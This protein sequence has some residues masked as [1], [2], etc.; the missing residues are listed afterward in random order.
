MLDLG[1]CRL[2]PALFYAQHKNYA[3]AIACVRNFILKLSKNISLFVFAGVFN[4]F[5]IVWQGTDGNQL[6]LT[7]QLGN[8][9]QAADEGGGHLG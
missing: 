3:P 6:Y 2:Q 8:I 7:A 5:A 1:K 9:A 4:D